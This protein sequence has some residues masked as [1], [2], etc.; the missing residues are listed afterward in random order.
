[1]P[2]F[3]SKNVLAADVYHARDVLF[4]YLDNNKDSRP[5]NRKVVLRLIRNNSGMIML[6]KWRRPRRVTFGILG[7]RGTTNF[8]FSMGTRLTLL[9]NLTHYC[10]RSCT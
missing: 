10:R 8:F 2:I 5:D 9:G 1:M 4:G 6:R 3:A 7:L